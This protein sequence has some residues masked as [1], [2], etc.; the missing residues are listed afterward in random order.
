MSSFF[1]F[2]ELAAARGD[3]LLPELRNLLERAADP[4]QNATIRRDGMVQAG[5]DPA[6][7]RRSAAQDNVVALPRGAGP[8]RTAAGC[9]SPSTAEDLPLATKPAGAAAE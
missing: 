8:R 3:G 6:S 9:G 5:P 7:E 4:R 2:H 1:D